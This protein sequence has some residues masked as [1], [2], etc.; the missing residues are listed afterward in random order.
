LLFMLVA[1]ELDP[2]LLDPVQEVLYL[3]AH[4]HDIGSE[5]P[6]VL[7]TLEVVVDNFSQLFHVWELLLEHFRQAA[8]LLLELMISVDQI[9]H[10]L[11]VLLERI[12]TVCGSNVEVVLEFLLHF[13]CSSPVNF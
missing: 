8:V 2:H 9:R 13:L 6:F 1:R 11:F 4:L 5:V 7:E 3:L 12:L 10:L